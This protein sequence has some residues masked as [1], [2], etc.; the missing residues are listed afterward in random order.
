MGERKDMRLRS[1]LKG[2][3]WRMTGTADTIFVSFLVTGRLVTAV[4]IGGIE[5]VTKIILYYSHERAW[6]NITWG[7]RQDSGQGKTAG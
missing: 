5:L 3:T 6:E 7:R 4:S 2:I 1:L